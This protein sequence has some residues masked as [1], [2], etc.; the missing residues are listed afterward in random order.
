MVEYAVETDLEVKNG[1]IWTQVEVS[2]FTGDRET[3]PEI[4]REDIV[5]IENIVWE[6]VERNRDPMTGPE[7]RPELPLNF[8]GDITQRDIY[9][10]MDRDIVASCFIKHKEDFIGVK[11]LWNFAQELVDEVKSQM[12][13]PYS[14]RNVQVVAES[15]VEQHHPEIVD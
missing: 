10:F 1:P 15:W 4:T 3:S 11:I 12:G 5:E 8:T 13:E 9:C 6:V 7:D 14:V 2:S